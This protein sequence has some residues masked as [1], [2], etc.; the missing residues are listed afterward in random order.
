[1]T[2][3]IRESRR[4]ASTSTIGWKRARTVTPAH[5]VLGAESGLPEIDSIELAILIR[6]SAD[7]EVRVLAD[8][9]VEMLGQSRG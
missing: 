9:L 6:P 2:A 7:P 5:V 1:M 3:M 8:M 4:P